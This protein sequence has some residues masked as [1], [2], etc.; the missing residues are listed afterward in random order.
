MSMRNSYLAAAHRVA[1]HHL[2]SMMAVG[3]AREIQTFVNQAVQRNAALRMD[4][5]AHHHQSGQC[6]GHH[7]FLHRSAPRARDWFR[8]RRVARGN[9]V[10]TSLPG[11]VADQGTFNINVPN[12]GKTDLRK[13]V[14]R[15]ELDS[16]QR[17]ETG[18]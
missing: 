9:R 18:A 4:H 7:R 12:S 5:T 14:M 16:M 11:A 2:V 8:G 6:G 3:V 1:A 15:G 17:K 10:R 13:T